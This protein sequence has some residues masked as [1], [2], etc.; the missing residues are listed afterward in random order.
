MPVRIDGSNIDRAAADRL[1]QSAYR[2][3]VGGD[4]RIQR[5]PVTSSVLQEVVA[6]RIEGRVRVVRRP[7]E[8]TAECVPEGLNST[9]SPDDEVRAIARPALRPRGRGNGCGDRRHR[10]VAHRNRVATH[11]EDAAEIVPWPEFL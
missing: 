1:E 4:V 5:R 8:S 7:T 2:A 10:E 11:H 6:K 3:Q 9:I